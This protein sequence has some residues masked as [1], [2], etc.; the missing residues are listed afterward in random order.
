MATAENK[1]DDI[2]TIEVDGRALEA[3]KGEMII[4]VTDRAGIDIPRFCYHHKLSI[5][6]NC[7]MC[8]VDVEK[9]PKPLPACAT[10]VADGMKVF[11]ESR[12]T[13]DA[14][15]GVME[16]L[17]I[18]HPLD[19][20]I[21]DQG[22]ECELQDLAMGYG[23]SVSRFTE[24]KRVV[25]DKNVGPLI[26]T[27]MTRCIHCTRCV[28]FLEEIAGTCELGGMSRGEH[29]EI[30][31]FVERNINSELSGNVIDLCPV[32]ALTNKPFRHTARPW[33]MRARKS[34]GTHDCL[35]SHLFYHTRGSKIMRAVPRDNEAVNECWLADRD[36][37]SHFGLQSADRLT[38]PQLKVDG[39][40]REA[41]WDE[42]LNAAARAL[43]GA[44]ETHGGSELGVLVSPRA[45]VEEHFL[46][47]SMARA[48]GSEN[49]DHRLRLLDFSH[50][51]AGRG[52]LDVP[53][54]KIAEA[55]AIVLVGSNIRH[56]Q[57][58]LGHRVRTA[59]RLNGAKIADLNS[60]AW[61]FHF[62][63]A[64]R[65]IVPPQAMVDTFA[66]LAKAAADLTGAKEPEGKLG[67]FIAA[68]HPEPEVQQV[69]SMLKDA[70]SGVLLLGDQA[71]NHP[72][73][74]W[75]R[76]IAE[77]LAQA[78]EVALVVLP[79]PANSM[80]AWAAGSVPGSGGLNARAMIEK[81]RQA[82]L[83]WDLEPD[84]DLADPAA[85][86]R[87]LE[88]AASV[89]AVTTFDN[90]VLRETANVLLPL[91]PLP[92]TAGSWINADGHREWLEA[93]GK[94][95]GEARPGWKILRRLGEL[96]GADGFD[97]DTL[98]SV[99]ERALAAEAI[100]PAHDKLIDPFEAE[101]E[102]LWR[103][104]EVPL[105]AGDSLQRRAPAL[106]Q[107][108]QAGPTAVRVHPAT[109][110]RH[111]LEGAE[112]V[113]VVQGKASTEMALVIDA[114]VAPGAVGLPVAVCPVSELGAGG[115][116]ISLEVSA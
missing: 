36:R 101:G 106:Q 96:A 110:R 17:L 87:A 100:D 24:R 58:I 20:P 7:R 79:G 84:F 115:G 111:G 107:T 41:S 22:G 65:L 30:G 76:Q 88:G 72:E 86:K 23:R 94:P 66:R 54:A 13:V 52:H 102:T 48:M 3:K 92:E 31:T 6:A 1:Q 108:N 21:C 113:R 28:R 57:P 9:A 67:E 55:D 46:A 38:T 112:R 40:W 35:G 104:G 19:C 5:A 95:P 63:L 78:L 25:R 59:W 27:D 8:L 45:T 93:V 51:Q 49:I 109:A 37:Y 4:Q 32:G 16:F 53:K 116:E 71:L 69:A 42:A 26:E 29:L 105:Y 56:E 44:V 61:D 98:E 90:S 34:I 114:R 15:R 97:F 39:Q 60:V 14:Q 85:S 103:T 64:E 75:L 80:G 2:V 77:W 89:V 43:K 11:T 91:A 12:R 83:L 73:A 81:G 99:T 70:D 68:R 74:G 82:Y 47:A 10:P 18:N 62:D 33:E 50:P